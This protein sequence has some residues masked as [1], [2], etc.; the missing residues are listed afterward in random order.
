MSSFTI[1][2]T[3]LRPHKKKG[4]II[5]SSKGVQRDGVV[6]LDFL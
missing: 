1:L 2:P 4:Q 3:D 5:F 6:F